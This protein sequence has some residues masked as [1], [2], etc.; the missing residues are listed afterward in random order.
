VAQ[1]PVFGHGT[2]SFSYKY[3][4]LAERQGMEHTTNSH[5]EYLMIAVQWGLIGVGVFI[6]LLYMMWKRSYDLKT[7]S[8]GC[9]LLCFI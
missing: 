4:E 7:Q 8:E 2:G 9:L 6:A 1:K 5:N 3:K